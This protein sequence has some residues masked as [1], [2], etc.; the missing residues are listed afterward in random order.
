ML[1]RPKTF[2][3]AG[4]KKKIN[5]VEINGSQIK[6]N[7]FMLSFIKASKSYD[8]KVDQGFVWRNYARLKELNPVFEKNEIIPP[9]VAVKLP[10]TV[11][12]SPIK[13]NDKVLKG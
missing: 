5:F 4:Y 3:I 13:I 12:E 6:F 7:L 11:L 8:G 1:Q 2:G 10:K 9:D